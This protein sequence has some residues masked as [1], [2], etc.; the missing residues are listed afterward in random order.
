VL[1]DSNRASYDSTETPIAYPQQPTWTPFLEF[2]ADPHRL[3]K[4]EF[5]RHTDLSAD[6]YHSVLEATIDSS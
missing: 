6:T 4:I 1:E 3:F 2:K 5:A